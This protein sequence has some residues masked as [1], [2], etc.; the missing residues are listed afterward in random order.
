MPR[1]WFPEIKQP[2]TC[3]R[4]AGQLLRHYDEIGCLQCGAPHTEEG[5]LAT[6]SA[7]EFS[8]D[9]PRRGRRSA[10]HISAHSC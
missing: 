4:C 3:Q 5:K 8:L 2:P 9:L 10:Y 1:Y 7:Q 6:Y